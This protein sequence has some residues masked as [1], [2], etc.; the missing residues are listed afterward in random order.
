[1]TD[2]AMTLL[3]GQVRELVRTRGLDPAHEARSRLSSLVEE[4]LGAYEDRAATASLPLLQN[5]ADAAR[6]LL[7]AVAGFGPLQSLMEDP[8]VEEVWI[9]AP[10]KVFCARSGH[11]VLTNIILEEGQ[12]KDL[13][14]R[15]L[16]S[17][18]RRLDVSSPFVD[19]MLPDGSR[20]H[21]AIPGV[22]R[23]H[24]AVNIRKFVLRV[25]HLSHLE[26]LGTLSAAAG[27]YL[28]AAVRAG[29]NI[30]VCGGTQTGKTT[31]LNCLAAAIPLR[32]RLITCEEVFELTPALPDVVSLQTRQANLE[33][34]G[35]ISLRRLILEALRMRPD[36][37]MVGEVRGAEALDLLI[38]LNSGLPAMTSL[39]ANSAADALVKLTTL[40]LLAAENVTGDFVVPTIARCVD[41]VVYLAWDD[42]KRIVDEI[43]AP[44]GRVE[45]RQIE[46]VPIFD[47]RSGP[48][49]WT[50]NPAPGG[51]R[52]RAEGFSLVGSA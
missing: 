21:V 3:E 36:R 9:N 12:T 32:E 25:N 51:A 42:R 28:T 22:T 16:R 47:R 40:P 50:G 38:A 41:V 29:M 27:D 10:G 26:G 39:H 20:L 30:V 43:T 17:S 19:A 11:R 49:R 14:E 23:R 2:P 15:M 18:G 34:A 13:I 6:S 35:E 52:L 7:D 48:L 37:L 33:G 24:W 44:T 8:S 5:R 45:G 4:V 1:M 46:T 31:M